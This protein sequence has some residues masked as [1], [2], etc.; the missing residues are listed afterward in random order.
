[1][2]RAYNTEKGRKNTQVNCPVARK[3]LPNWVRLNESHGT[4][5][6]PQRWRW[7]KKFD[8]VVLSLSRAAAGVR[9][10]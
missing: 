7:T 9:V 2:T 1:M 3:L 5:K 4:K 10:I 8:R 6:D